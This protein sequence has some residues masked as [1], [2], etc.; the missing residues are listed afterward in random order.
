MNEK[1]VS[2]TPVAEPLDRQAMS[3][4]VIRLLASNGYPHVLVSFADEDGRYWVGH[5]TGM[6]E[7]ELAVWG[8]HRVAENVLEDAQ[9]QSDLRERSSRAFTP[10]GGGGGGAGGN[11]SGQ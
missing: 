2:V 10:G 6:A 7:P 8:L 9:R 5:T 11:G 4:A 3:E 1:T